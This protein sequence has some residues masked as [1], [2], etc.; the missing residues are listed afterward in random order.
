MLEHYCIHPTSGQHLFA[1]QP[2]ASFWQAAETLQVNHFLPQ[3][4]PH[5]PPTQAQVLYDADALYVRFQVQ[6]QY[7]RAVHTQYQAQ[8]SEDSCVELFVQPVA[9]KGYFNVEFNCCGILLLY[10]IEDPQRTSMGFVCFQQVDPALAGQI[11]VI[12]TFTAPIRAEITTPV[13][14]WLVYQLP[15]RVL[16]AYVGPVSRTPGTRWR[17]NFF[18]CGD[19]TSHPHWASWAPIQNGELNFHQPAYFGVLELG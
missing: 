8:V 6:D 17:G 10:Y 3:S 11:R 15:F 7:V 12:S 5:R 4:S 9:N 1:A 16:E 19:H 14:W 13:S 2:D 18:K